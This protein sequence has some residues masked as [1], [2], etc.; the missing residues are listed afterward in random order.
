M[1]CVTACGSQESKNVYLKNENYKLEGFLDNNT[2]QVIG[3]GSWPEEYANKRQLEKSREARNNALINAQNKVIQSF[4]KSALSV[5]SSLDEITLKRIKNYS[6]GGTVV[7]TTYD[8]EF[9]CTVVY[10][11]NIPG[12][13]KMAENGFKENK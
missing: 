10:R 1:F 8:D 6:S 13:K 3:N 12:L 4:K 7:K 11:V 9:N 2:F 5:S